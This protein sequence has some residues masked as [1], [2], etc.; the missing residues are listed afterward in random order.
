MRHL[1]LSLLEFRRRWYAM[2]TRMRAVASLMFA[3]AF[4][5]CVLVWAQSVRQSREWLL[6]GQSFSAR[7]LAHIEGAF[8]TAG[9]SRYDVQ[10]GRI[11]IPR[12]KR[13]EYVAAMMAGQA[14]PARLRTQLPASTAG[15]FLEN[16]S[17]RQARM[18]QELEQK[19]EMSVLSMQGIEDATVHIDEATTGTGFQR[20]NQVTAMVAVMPSSQGL[21]PRLVRSIREL[22]AGAKVELRPSSV[23]VT[24]LA[25]GK[26]WSG[27]P[28]QDALL[29]RM[30]EYNLRKQQYEQEWNEKL[31][32]LL[33]FIPGV[34]VTTNV[35]LERTPPEPDPRATNQYTWP[36]SLSAS[37]VNVSVSVPGDYY[38]HVARQ[39][40]QAG[41]VVGT[42]DELE[43]ETRQ[44]VEQ[45]VSQLMPQGK[46]GTL[47]SR[48]TVMTLAD[49][50]MQAAM[51]A[52]NAGQNYLSDSSGQAIA[53]GSRKNW[54]GTF[55]RS[56]GQP[57]GDAANAGAGKFYALVLAAVGF[58]L[59][60]IFGFG[61]DLRRLVADAK[62]SGWSD[63]TSRMPTS[64]LAVRQG[65][66]S[67]PI[68]EPEGSE[69]TVESQRVENRIVDDEEHSSTVLHE[70][71]THIVRANPTAA[72]SLL[73]QW[74]DK[75]A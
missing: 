75:A 73:Q 49:L 23:T 45:L 57:G 52:S 43:V 71:I 1:T 65:D 9:L 40:K 69:P 29:A 34:Q 74:L 50:S 59:L 37:A 67:L 18:R 54:S 16:S 46:G 72:A 6:A 60:A 58:G 53:V 28:E 22:V 32:G 35:N 61:K 41:Q 20:K 36:R 13:T 14:L 8:A 12:S 62:S 44:T 66:D 21:S 38:R 4:L 27:S 63:E 26:A 48:V 31:R 39:R 30:D 11:L 25:S 3:A 55:S 7:E 47:S 5:L 17:Q 2:P 51:N 64:E 19:L 10:Q 15:S 56:S 70:E 42:L 24:D 68:G 33:R